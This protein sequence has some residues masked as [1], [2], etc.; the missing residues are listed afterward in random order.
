MVINQSGGTISGFAG[1][2]GPIGPITVVNAGSIG[3]NP[4]TGRGLLLGAGGSVT[5]QAGG[6]ISGA[7]GIYAG[8]SVTVVNAGTIA[9]YY[10]NASRG[11]IWQAAAASPTKAAA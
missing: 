1:V 7:V 6:T 10:K 8:A 5:N 4:T 9:S 2:Y 11:F 3:G